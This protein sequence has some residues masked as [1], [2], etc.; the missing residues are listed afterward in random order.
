MSKGRREGEEERGEG[1]MTKFTD[2]FFDAV[3]ITSFKSHPPMY[4]RCVI[5]SPLSLCPLFLSLVILFSF[6]LLS[7]FLLLT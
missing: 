2:L 6:S 1:E 7:F 4:N 3:P 5:S